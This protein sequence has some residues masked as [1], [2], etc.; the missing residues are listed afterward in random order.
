MINFGYGNQ[1]LGANKSC[2]EKSFKFLQHL[3]KKIIL[4]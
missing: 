3:A 1:S 4:E 2:V